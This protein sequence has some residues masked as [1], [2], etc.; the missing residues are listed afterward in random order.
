MYTTFIETNA[1]SLSCFDSDLNRE[2]LLPPLCL[3]LDLTVNVSLV[4]KMTAW[5]IDLMFPLL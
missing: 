1:A 3:S 5:H 4:L 2:F